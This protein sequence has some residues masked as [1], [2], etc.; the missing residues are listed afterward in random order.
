MHTL[1]QR[2]KWHFVTKIVLTYCEKKLFWWSRKTFEIRGQRPNICKNFEITK[3]ICS[4][5]QK[6]RTSSLQQMLCVSNLKSC[7]PHEKTSFNKKNHLVFPIQNYFSFY[8]F[9]QKKKCGVVV[10]FTILLLRPLKLYVKAKKVQRHWV[11][12]G[13]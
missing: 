4:N 9:F 12:L 11:G 1:F 8:F 7:K 3:T 5:S 13:R 10:I 2:Q 6:V